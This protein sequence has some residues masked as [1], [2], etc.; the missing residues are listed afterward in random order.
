MLNLTFARHGQR[1]ENTACVLLCDV[2]AYVEM[3]L[4]SCCLETGCITPLFYCCVGVLLSNGCFCGATVLAWSKY[5][6][7]C[8]DRYCLTVSSHLK[9]WCQLVY[10]HSYFTAYCCTVLSLHLTLNYLASCCDFCF[11]SSFSLHIRLPPLLS[12]QTTIVLSLSSKHIYMPV[13]T[14]R[15]FW[16]LHKQAI[17]WFSGRNKNEKEGRVFVIWGGGGGVCWPS[18]IVVSLLLF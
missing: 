12:S 5:A 3:C 8:W 1:T 16:W 14:S 6:I 11:T 9:S 15:M 10:V 13:I 2:T 18:C 7:I 17:L 4:P